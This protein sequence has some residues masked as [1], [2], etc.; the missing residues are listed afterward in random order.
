LWHTRNV[1]PLKYLSQ[2]ATDLRA[3]WVAHVRA[4][5]NALPATMPDP[6]N[7]HHARVPRARYLDIM[8]KRGRAVSDEAKHLANVVHCIVEVYSP[9]GELKRSY[10]PARSRTLMDYAFGV[11]D[12]LRLVDLGEG[13]WR[14]L[15]LCGST[16]RAPAGEMHNFAN[17]LKNGNSGGHANGNNDAANGR[18]AGRVG[19]AGRAVVGNAGRAVVGNDGRTTNARNVGTANAPGAA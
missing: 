12:T 1:A 9:A 4:H 6:S 3:R 14:A 16:A 19:N 15:V 5:Q 7:P 11:T 18:N 17:L 8:A 2:A 13:K 10:K